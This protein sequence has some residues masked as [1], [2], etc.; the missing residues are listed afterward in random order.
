M[1]FFDNFSS[2][3]LK[4]L[5]AAVNQARLAQTNT[6]SRWS[7]PSPLDWS[8]FALAWCNMLPLHARSVPIAD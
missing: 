2:S 5:E 1:S 6:Q 4:L 7:L 8:L 3:G